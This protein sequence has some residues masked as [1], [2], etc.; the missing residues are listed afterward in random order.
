MEKDNKK[1]TYISPLSAAKVSAFTTSAIVVIFGA[2]GLFFALLG[3]VAGGEEFILGFF[4]GLLGFMA[5]L[6]FYAL[7]GFVMGYFYAW[8]YNKTY[9]W[10]GGIDITFITN[11]TK[12]SAD[13]AEE[14]DHEDSA[15][16]SEE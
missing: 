7:I 5:A 3:A 14:S 2:I 15:N 16:E 6:A 10:H 1:I 12:Q 4:F 11:E 8:V 13:S 9:Q